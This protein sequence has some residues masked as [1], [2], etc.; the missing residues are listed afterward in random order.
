MGE[1]GPRA[2]ILDLQG[3]LGFSAMELV[4]RN[5]VAACDERGAD[6]I[7]LD[8]KR[9]SRVDLGVA[10]ML[11]NL[12]HQLAA[13]DR[14]L[15][16]SDVER[17][18]KLMSY[19]RHELGGVL[20]W[21][22]LI[23]ADLDAALEWCEDRL[24]EEAGLLV[25]ASTVIPLQDHLFCAGLVE[26]D[27]ATLAAMAERREFA[28]GEMLVRAGEPPDSL[29]LLSRGALS[30]TIDLAEGG[31]RRL[32]T[33]LPGMMFGELSIVNR[34]ARSAD[35]RADTAGECYMLSLESLDRLRD[36]N[37]ALKAA[38]L[39]NVLGATAQTVYRLSA[40]VRALAG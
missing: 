33:L 38:L 19:L 6:F 34:N 15:L 12:L 28:R 10:W 17:H 31:V 20:S 24:L 11:V 4:T 18:A 7:V 36:E 22:H 37:P 5:A 39:E 16:F 26:A 35:V 3:D 1:I 13:Q 14:R 25:D 29:Y 21:A 40:E 8:F 27:I 32:A 30:V 2:V 23:H 9:V